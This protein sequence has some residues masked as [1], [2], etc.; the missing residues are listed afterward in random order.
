MR[1]HGY[2]LI[3]P[4]VGMLM[5][6]PFAVAFAAPAPNSAVIKE[7][8]FND[9]PGSTLTTVDAYPANIKISDDADD[10]CVGFANLHNWRFSADNTTP[11]QFLNGDAF[12]ITADFILSGP[13]QAEGG[14]QV[15]PWFSPDI[16]GR[17]NVRTTDGEV[18]VFGGVLPFY[19]FTANHGVVY[20]KGTPIHLEISYDPRSNTEA[21]PA[22][23]E[24]RLM[25]ASNSYTSGG[26][27]MT[28][29]NM[30]EQPT[31]GCYGILNFA[32]VGGHFQPL[33]QAGQGQAITADWLDITYSPAGSTPAKPATW[34]RLKTLYR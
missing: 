23:M 25:Y 13:G 2:K 33:W 1:F 8:I 10:G 20:V 26:L 32:Q 24:Y 4:V 22:I 12:T 7:R 6:L 21:D 5:A 28:G 29:C 16:D 31:Y 3:T 18:A 15:S 19:N 27:P 34:G 30:S 17:F 14:L 11:I 9:C